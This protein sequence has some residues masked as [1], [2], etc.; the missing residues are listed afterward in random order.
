[1]LSVKHS[2]LDCSCR[3]HH[4]STC[5]LLVT[6]TRWLSLTVTA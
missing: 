5:L 6:C 4:N 1:M 2:S 3:L